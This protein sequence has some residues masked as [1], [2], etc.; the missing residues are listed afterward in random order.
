MKLLIHKCPEPIT[1]LLAGL[2]AITAVVVGC[3][4]V[5]G[6]LAGFLWLVVSAL[7][8]VHAKIGMSGLLWIGGTLLALKVVSSIGATVLKEWDK[9]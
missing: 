2:A 3:L 9:C 7:I 6:I 5:G 8:W 4:L 1:N